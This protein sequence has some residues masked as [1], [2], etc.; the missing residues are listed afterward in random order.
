ME[1]K[2]EQL[3]NMSDQELND[4]REVAHGNA[5]KYGKI[6]NPFFYITMATIVLTITFALIDAAWADTASIITF[7]VQFVTLI[8]FVLL[9]MVE[10]KWRSRSIRILQTLIRRTEKEYVT[11]LKKEIKDLKA[12]KEA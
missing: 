6:A 11:A 7:I 5:N 9:S 8:A 3:D 4:L 10:M 2:Q 1:Y 12:K